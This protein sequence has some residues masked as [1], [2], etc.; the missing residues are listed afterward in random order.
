[1]KDNRSLF[2]IVVEGVSSTTLGQE[3][4]AGKVANKKKLLVKENDRKFA[5]GEVL[6]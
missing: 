1:M 4:K 2:V 6:G 5:F 3:L